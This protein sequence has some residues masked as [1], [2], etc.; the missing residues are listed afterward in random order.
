MSFGV[1]AGRIVSGRFKYD[2]WVPDTSPSNSQALLRDHLA[3]LRSSA[4][5]TCEVTASAPLACGLYLNPV[6]EASLQ[7]EITLTLEHDTSDHSRD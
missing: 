7:C 5:I 3:L 4:A 2:E 1:S 6:A